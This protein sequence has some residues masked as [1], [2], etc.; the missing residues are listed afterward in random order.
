MIVFAS[1]FKYKDSVD[2]EILWSKLTVIYVRG[3]EP[4]YDL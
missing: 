2:S 1:V 4:N 3:S